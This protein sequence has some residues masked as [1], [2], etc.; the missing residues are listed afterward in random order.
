MSRPTATTHRE[1]TQGSPQMTRRFTGRISIGGDPK[2][3]TRGGRRQKRTSALL[4]QGRK[5][6]DEE[7]GSYF[8][9]WA[10]VAC[11]RR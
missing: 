10:G 9:L 7:G 11:K 6:H 5:G 4:E 1:R 8:L 2:G 3:E